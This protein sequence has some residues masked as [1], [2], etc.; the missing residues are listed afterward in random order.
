MR[1]AVLI[2]LGWLTVSASAQDGSATGGASDVRSPQPPAASAPARPL[3]E[4]QPPLYYLKDKDGRLQA[5]PGFS[6]ENFIEAYKLQHEFAQRDA[7]PRFT[8]ER[9]AA[10]GKVRP[11]QAQLTVEVTVLVHQA[12]W[13][14]VPLRLEQ[15]ILTSSAADSRGQD[16]WVEYDE[17]EGYRL[18]LRAAADQRKTV[19]LEFLAPVTRLG[20]TWRMRLAAPRATAAELKL[21]VPLADA[22]AQCNEGAV[23]ETAAADK[24][25]TEFRVRGLGGD[26]ELTW[27]PAETKPHGTNVTLE[28]MGAI[29][30]RIDARELSAEALLTVRSYGEPFDRFHVRLPRGAVLSSSGASGYTVV[31]DERGATAEERFVE[32]RLNKKTIGPL[33]VRIAARNRYNRLAADQWLELSGFEVLESPRQWGHITVATVGDWHVLWGP[34][35]GVRQT[36]QWPESLRQDDVIA[37]FEY[38]SQPFALFARLIPRKTHVSVEPEYLVL[39]DPD[40][41]RLEAKLK[42]SIRG[43]KAYAFDVQMSDWELDQIEPEQLVATDGV[44]QNDAQMLSI[45]LVQPAGGQVELTV[46]AHRPIRPGTKSLLVPLPQPQAQ[47]VEPSTVVVLPADNVQLTPGGSG[48]IG[49]TRQQVAPQLQLPERQQEPLHYRG[50]SPK[51][52]FA[53][54]FGVQPQ[55]VAVDVASQITL[56]SKSIQVEQKLSFSISYEPLERITLHAPRSA[57]E[58]DALSVLLDGTA[59]RPVPAADDSRSGPTAT[60][61]V[62]L[63]KPCLG[64]CELIVRYALPAVPLKDDEP[65]ALTVPLVMPLGAKLTSNRAAVL[66]APG[67]I[68]RLDRGTWNLLADESLRTSRSRLLQATAAT[69]AETLA[70]RIN[71]DSS[72]LQPATV[73]ERAWIQT[74]LTSVGLRQDRAVFR[75]TSTEKEVNLSLPEGVV[76]NQMLVLLDGK[77]VSPQAE[78]DHWTLPLSGESGQ[79]QHVVELRYYFSGTIGAGGLRDFQFP[80]LGRDP[81]VRR[82]Y[83]QLVVPPAMHVLAASDTLTRESAWGFNGLFWSQHPLLEQPA[84]EA[85]VGATRLAAVPEGSQRYLFSSMGS[86]TGGEV[87]LMSRSTIVLLAS[88]TV[89][90]VGL[91][92][93]YVP[94]LRH[95]ALLLVAGV[96]LLAG[97][98]LYPEPAVLLAQGCSLGLLL[99]VFAAVLKRSL[100]RPADEPPMEPS[101]SFSEKGSTQIRQPAAAT[102]PASTASVSPPAT[103]D[104]HV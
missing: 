91:L 81:W 49:L 84:L 72:D 34:N 56:E 89:L 69:A 75:I 3:Q 102:S 79:H 43:A 101:R 31:G 15:A 32:V 5:V 29:Q 48:M 41:V 87:L 60:L 104:W 59:L 1:L 22:V 50:E 65:L 7:K 10:S 24:Q 97:G 95:P 47:S 93:L 64:P 62:T 83:W 14:R 77:S 61:S 25:S 53:A 33:D 78:G 58:A 86:I 19:K 23:L 92:L 85:W 80:Q 30:T 45:P 21:T 16:W 100:G 51:A 11:E 27:Q 13:V 28:V 74:W 46:R 35:R 52:V 66:P 12:D 68:V 55:T 42:Y 94:V 76:V 98:V 36:D 9:F 8:L 44:S 2:A 96:A 70:L 20:S 18:W 57:V 26:F 54:Q 40:Q 88:G 82:M 63:P 6:Y 90:A 17:S 99:T 71:R 67:T 39:V 38:F 4:V 37:G 73:V 103:L